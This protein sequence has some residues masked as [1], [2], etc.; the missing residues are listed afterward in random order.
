[1]AENRT[2]ARPYANALFEVARDGGDLDGWS[3]ALASAAAVAQNEDA[4][5]F[6][7]SPKVSD[8]ERVSL[9]VE[10]AQGGPLASGHGQNLLRL[11]AENDRFEVLP[12]IAARFEELK[13][14]FENSVEVSLISA[15]PVDPAIAAKI[16]AALQ[17]R[18]GRSVELNESIDPDLVGGAIIRADDM[19]ID[20]SIRTRLGQLAQAMKR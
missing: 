13:A 7:A 4:Q 11:L 3:K 5:S 2:L 16:K 17:K 12:E 9:V 10:L 6:F 15:T 19:V 14:K 8:A 18:L 1:M 20:G